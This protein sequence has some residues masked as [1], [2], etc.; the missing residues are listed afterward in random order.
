MAP[1]RMTLWGNPT[2]ITDKDL[3]WGKQVGI[4]LYFLASQEQLV[5]MD[6]Q[7]HNLHSGQ[8]CNILVAENTVSSVQD[9]YTY[10]D[11]IVS[12]IIGQLI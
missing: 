6:L 10:L 5:S 9:I 7:R 2:S 12:I 1:A 11:N 3:G 4:V 8:I